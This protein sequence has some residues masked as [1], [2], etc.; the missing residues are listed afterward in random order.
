MAGR[1]HVL[2]LLYARLCLEMCWNAAQDVG[3]IAIDD[4]GFGGPNYSEDLNSKIDQAIKDAWALPQII[5]GAG[6]FTYI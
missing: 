3:S 6:I 5:H 1:N 4:G 2:R